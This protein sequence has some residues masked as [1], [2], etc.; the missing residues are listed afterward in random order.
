MAAI[1]FH[2]GDDYL[3]QGQ[4]YPATGQVQGKII[5][6]GA[7]GVPQGFLPSSPVSKGLP[8]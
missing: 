7:T 6:A 5:V 4:L 2:T 3:I 1:S 8:P